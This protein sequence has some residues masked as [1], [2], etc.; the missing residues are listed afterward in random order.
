MSETAG[1]LRP[2]KAYVAYYAT[3]DSEG[4]PFFQPF[5]TQRT[6]EEPKGALQIPQYV[7]ND[8]SSEDL[9]QY[10][11]VLTERVLR[12][13]PLLLATLET[14]DLIV[15]TGS[16][17]THIMHRTFDRVQKRAG[18]TTGTAWHARTQQPGLWYRRYWRQ[19]MGRLVG[20][21]CNW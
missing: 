18:L 5:L 3:V 19:I 14:E 11:C 20:K 2:G 21:I 7:N 9:D 8:F 10:A 4:T 6:T 15:A 17:Q 12:S 13:W 16:S 1:T